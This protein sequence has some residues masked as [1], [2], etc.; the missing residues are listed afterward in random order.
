M[1]N[2]YIEFVGAAVLAIFFIIA[3]LKTAVPWLADGGSRYVPLIA[4]A[5]G[6]GVA[7]YA[8]QHW[9]LNILEVLI[10]VVIPALGASGLHS[11]IN[12]VKQ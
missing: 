5:L 8:G 4:L 7:I 12:E 9:S 1:D 10:S 3:I 11:Y 6:V 2:A